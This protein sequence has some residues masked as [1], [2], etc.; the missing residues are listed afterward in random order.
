MS[1]VADE[2]MMRSVLKDIIQVK[3]VNLELNR[4]VECH[5]DEGRMTDRDCDIL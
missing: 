5:K 1:I 3:C 4:C 2:F